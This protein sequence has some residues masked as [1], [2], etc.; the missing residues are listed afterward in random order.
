MADTETTTELT[1]ERAQ[2]LAKGGGAR[3][4]DVRQ[5]REHDAAHIR[6]DELIQFD[7]LKDRAR[8]FDP[9]EPIVLYCRS[10]D[11]SGAAVQALRASGYDAYS[12]DGGI[13]AWTEQ[14][15][16][17]EPADGEIVEPSSLPPA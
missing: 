6:G 9:S 4:I 5:P 12:I 10:G 16:P 15:L 1:P 3:V 8:E 17:I 14:G 7:E 13:L 2:E 11:R